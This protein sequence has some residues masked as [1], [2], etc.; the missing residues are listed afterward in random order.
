MTPRGASSQDATAD[1][2]VAQFAADVQDSLGRVPRQLPSRYFYDPLGSAL[3]DAICHLPWYHITRAESR[4]L[5]AH[6]AQLCRRLEPL[7][8]IVELGPGNGGKL[9][10]LLESAGPSRGHLDLH[11]VDVSAQA[12]QTAAHTLGTLR[13]VRIAVHAAEYEAGLRQV[14]SQAAGSQVDGGRTLVLFLGSNIGNFDVP[15]AA[16]LLA[17]VR[18]SLSGGD[19]LLLGTDLVKPERDLLLAYDDPLGVTAAFNRNLLVRLN[20]E[21]GADFAI[22]AFVHRAVWNPVASRMEMHL[23]ARSTQLVRFGAIPLELTL[24]AGERIWTESSYKYQPDQVAAMVE[25]ARFRAAAQWIDAE[26]GFLLT[27]AEAA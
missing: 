13:A 3:F 20:R 9:K 10:I 8:T 18:E 25:A 21:L 7:S 15:G 26:D 17:S 16:A 19:A 12:L 11:L 5:A 2:A 23:E 24:R 1:A 22:D 14:M 27:V 6:G 4:L